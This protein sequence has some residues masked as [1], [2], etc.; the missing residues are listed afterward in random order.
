MVRF[1]RP[2]LAGA[3]AVMTLTGCVIVNDSDQADLENDP[4][5]RTVKDGVEFWD[6]TGEPTAEALGI[7]SDRM[8]ADYRSDEPRRIVLQLEGGRSLRFEAPLLSF[9]RSRSA[10]G[11]AFTLGSRGATVAPADLGDQLTAL[12][13]QLS[14]DPDP[15]V[16]S[17]LAEVAQAPDEQTE[18][19]RYSSPEQVYGDLTIGVS[20]DV[21]PIAGAGRFVVGGAWAAPTS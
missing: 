4:T 20:A 15:G 16:E 10:G 6:L 5:A 13:E 7:R 11:D 8:S 19:V 1:L 9:T 18:R 12:T 14:G 2:L 3:L 17:F 21:A